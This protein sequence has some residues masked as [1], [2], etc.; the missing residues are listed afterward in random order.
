VPIRCLRRHWASHQEIEEKDE[1][2]SSWPIGAAIPCAPFRLVGPST[3]SQPTTCLAY[4]VTAIASEPTATL[5]SQLIT[6]DAWLRNSKV[7]PAGSPLHRA[8][9]SSPFWTG[10]EL[11]RPPHT[12]LSACTPR[13]QTPLST[14]LSFSNASYRTAGRCF[15]ARWC[16]AQT[17]LSK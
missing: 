3:Q 10:P 9:P 5:I 17:A 4:P 6:Q 2:N 11:L 1:S 13:D 8:Q 7:I 16:V 15:P 12:S 14:A